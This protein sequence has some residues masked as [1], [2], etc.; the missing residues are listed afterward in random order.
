M[1][2]G[3]NMGRRGGG[4][5]LA[6]K[7]MVVLTLLAVLAGMAGTTAVG[8]E[9]GRV[10]GNAGV[11]RGGDDRL[12]RAEMLAKQGKVERAIRELRAAVSEGGGGGR[13][14][15]HVALGKLLMMTSPAGS[16]VDAQQAL[17]SAV[18]AYM[19]DPGS[20]RDAVGPSQG[21]AATTLPALWTN[22]ATLRY[23][24]KDPEGAS[25]ACKEALKLT[26]DHARCLYIHAVACLSTGE[27]R[28][29][30][31]RV[32]SSLSAAVKLFR[33]AGATEEESSAS[34][35]L[36]T[37]H[38]R[39]GELE[40]AKAALEASLKFSPWN[41]DG[42]LRL[43]E[44]M[45]RLGSHYDALVVYQRMV[46]LRP[47]W[48][49][50][51]L[52]AGNALRRLGQHVQ[53]LEAYSEAMS[54][55]GLQPQDRAELLYQTGT[56][57]E[58]QGMVKGAT[59]AYGEAI[60]VETGHSRALNNLASIVMAKGKTSEAEKLYR[61]AVGADPYMYEAYNNLGGLLLS[62]GRDADSVPILEHAVRLEG[63]DAQVL[64]NLGL[65]YRRTGRS[66]DGVTLMRDALK[67]NPGNKDYYWE[68]A[69]TYT[70]QGR[71]SMA[72]AMLDGMTRVLRTGWGGVDAH[73]DVYVH[74]LSP[75][76]TFYPEEEGGIPA[77]FVAAETTE[78]V[79]GVILFLCCGD[80]TE[81][82]EL[83]HALGSLARHYT[84]RFPHP[85]VIF[86]DMLTPTNETTLTSAYGAASPLSFERIELAFPDSFPAEARDRVPSKLHL[87]GHAWGMGYRHMSRFFSHGLFNLSAMQGYEY[88][89]R[90]DADSFLLED[91]REDL[92][93]RMRAKSKV[94]GYMVVTQEDDAVVTGLWNA[95]K[96]Y[97]R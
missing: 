89:L 95:T 30:E 93:V 32:G 60:E 2:L 65:A 63:G 45:S 19:A 1:F 80:Q 81:L 29:D 73:P 26:P 22:I 51:R 38:L 36:G 13:A 8:E 64:F 7:G 31:A 10:D 96:D 92:F 42:L 57:L 91:V 35:A 6:S 44:A 43:G 69:R 79:R 15:P 52:Q 3:D 34:F 17:E 88:Y 48:A 86:H 49:E 53:A 47:D 24:N 82:Q 21:F 87:A 76:L 97:I 46:K 41:Y 25:E 75:Y 94:Y 74:T 68:L 4:G 84:R 16:M 61:R 77:R 5:S 67:I 54:L 56:V 11:G 37:L 27:W 90:L 12:T 58:Q 62:A 72:L 59:K 71:R 85:V 23:Q 66:G 70:F 33:A 9:G 28:R 18:A 40:R 83:H 14:A 55:P 78:K 50:P 20:N 39:R